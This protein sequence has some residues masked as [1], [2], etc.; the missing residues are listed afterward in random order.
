MRSITTI[1]KR[2]LGPS[3]SHTVGPTIASKIFNRKYPDRDRVEVTLYG[4][5]ALTG[6]GHKTDKAIKTFLPEAE[7]IFDYDTKD[8]PHPNTV[9]FTAYKDGKVV[10][11]ETCMSV[12]GGDIKF[13][14]TVSIT[15]TGF[16]FCF[17]LA[18]TLEPNMVFT[19][20]NIL[21]HITLRLAVMSK[22]YS[23]EKKT[24]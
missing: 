8:L 15:L 2:G 13:V 3:S 1:F 21:L 9:T 22:L 20:E 23:E 19:L 17:V 5:L 16:V 6:K 4:S 11:K 14:G 10:G 12:G 7:I 24:I 18:P